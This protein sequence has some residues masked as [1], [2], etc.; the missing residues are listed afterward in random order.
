MI[1][2]LIFDLETI[3][4]IKSIRRLYNLDEALS[5]FDV[6]NIAN[7][8]R[9][10][11]VGHDFLPVHLHQ[12]VAIS[13]V[14]K[15]DDRLEIWTL[16]D[17][18]TDE[19]GILKYFFVGLDKYTPNLVSWNGS[20]F[21][22]PVL[23]YRMLANKISSE[24]Y[25][26]TGENQSEFKWNN[27]MSRYHRR[28]LDLMDILAMFNGRNNASLNEICKIYGFPG[29]LDMDGGKV[30]ETFLNGDLASI[31][32]Y[33]ETDVANTYLV[34]LRYLLAKNELTTSAYKN[35]IDNFR[36]VISNYKKSHWSNFL[37]AWA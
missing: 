10:Q 32:N 29:K 26:D 7:F 24:I 9:R 6:V 14:L 18:E 25:F 8:K 37:K 17:E 15:T 16:G 30:W 2:T 28:H 36:N 11:K 27:Y 22:L 1:P 5:D 33:C 4:D 3:P 12:V 23:N 19:A 20:G 35:E 13:C 31:R 21:D 34:Y